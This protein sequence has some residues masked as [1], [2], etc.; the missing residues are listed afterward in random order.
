MKIIPIY[1]Y[2]RPDGGVSVSPNKPDCEYTEM[3]RIIADEGCALCKGE[4]EAECI[5]TDN[6]DGWEET[7]PAE[8]A[9]ELI[10]GGETV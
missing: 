10:I 2:T 5:D 6:V 1:R 3:F 7:L 4:L 8:K 9:L